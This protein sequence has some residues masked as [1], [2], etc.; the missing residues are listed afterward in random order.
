MYIQ[1]NSNIFS[2]DIFSPEELKILELNCTKIKLGT[3]GEIFLLKKRKEI[4]L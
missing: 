4:P 2:S 3:I 1:F